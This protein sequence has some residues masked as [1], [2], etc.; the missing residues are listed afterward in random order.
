[1]MRKC[2]VL[3]FA[4]VLLLPALSWASELT[5]EDFVV[6]ST[7]DLVDLCSVKADSPIAKEAIHFC[8]GFCVGAYHYYKA[9]HDGPDAIQWVCF[10][11]PAPSRTAVIDQFVSWAKAHP[12]YMK[13]D[14]VETLFRFLAEK[15]PCNK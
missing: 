2:V 10:P 9:S 4:V 14:A 3:I 6:D 15:Y 8:E 7:E 13:E 11:K 12:K 5:V 1:M